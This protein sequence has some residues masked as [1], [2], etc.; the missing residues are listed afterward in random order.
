M[1]RD[2]FNDIGLS[3]HDIQSVDDLYKIPIIDKKDFHDRDASE[4]IN[5]QI[6]DKERLISLRTSG[7]TGISLEFLIDRHYEQFRKAQF[8]RPYLTNGNGLFDKTLWFRAH[9][10]EEKGWFRK[11]GVLKEYQVYSGLR[12]EEQIKAIQKIKPA[13]IKGYGS[14]MGLLAK[15]ILDE[16]IKIVCPKIIFT[17]SE[18]LTDYL[19]AVI[20]EAFQVKIIDI[21]GTFET[22]NIGY[23]CSSHEGYHISTDTVILELI[24]DRQ[25]VSPGEQGEFVCTVLDNLT[26]PFIRY[27]LHDM[28]IYSESMCSCGRTFPLLKKIIGRSADYA[29]RENGEKV[30]LRTITGGIWPLAHDIYEFQVTQT[31]YNA[32]TILVVP[33]RVY[34]SDIVEK[35][36]KVIRV[37]FPNAQ[38]DVKLVD[39]IN[40]EASG[41]FRVFK[42]LC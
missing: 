34:S 21:F 5:E 6:K 29:L 3:P 41:K 15:K 16:N 32:F 19:R 40:R 17:D 30:S 14:V 33:S 11:F 35:L 2:K 36:Q 9:P 10:V 4:V 23:E 37:I 42:S 7:S 20:E 38:V 1:Y 22:E 28:G 39:T 12:L 27:N 18:L 31:D 24:N 8:L 25:K 13:I 26:T